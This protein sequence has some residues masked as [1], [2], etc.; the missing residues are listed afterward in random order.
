MARKEHGMKAERTKYKR[1]TPKTT[2]EYSSWGIQ[3]GLSAEILPYLA[4]AIKW[5]FGILYMNRSSTYSYR[6]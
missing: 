6:V 1:T 2:V 3:F 4:R 5:L